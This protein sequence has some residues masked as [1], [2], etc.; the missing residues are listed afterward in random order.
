[1]AYGL[2]LSVWQ[3]SVDFK[4]VK[5]SGRS[6][7]L[8]RAGS[9]GTA[10]QRLEEHYAGALAAG[11]SIGAY[12]FSYALSAADAA[13]EAEACLKA[14]AG[15]KL[16]YPVAFDFEDAS[17]KNAEKKGVSLTPKT[18]TDMALAFCDRIK[19]GGFAA[20]IYA[21]PD[22]LKRW[23]QADRIAGIDLW[24]AAWGTSDPPSAD[25]SGSC[26]IWQYAVLGSADD[27]K[28][29]RASAVGSIPGVSGAVDADVSYKDYTADYGDRF[30]TLAEIPAVYRPEIA[31]LIAA[32]ALKGTDSGLD[33]S[34][35]MI[36]SMIVAK[37][38]ADI[39][40]A[41]KAK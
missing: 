21:N 4:K 39:V 1:M 31:G 16:A 32:G 41:G 12:W 19:V 8:I 37:R 27:V 22:Y 13:G 24:L 6:F 23:Y 20:A 18:V 14:I 11:L 29:G 34:Q 33:L 28:N 36:R 2:D 40:A 7:V 26:Q 15:K 30:N 38:Y 9:G 35:D 5:E 25:K 17:V 3:K 10:D